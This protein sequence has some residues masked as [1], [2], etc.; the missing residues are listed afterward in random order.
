MMASDSFWKKLIVT[1]DNFFNSNTIV[2]FLQEESNQSRIFDNNETSLLLDKQFDA[3][4]SLIA[5]LKKN[6]Y[7]LD[8]NE[9]VFF[10]K[11]RSKQEIRDLKLKIQT[12]QRYG[13]NLAVQRD[14]IKLTSLELKE[15]IYDFFKYLAKNWTVLH[16]KDIK[17]Y[18]EENHKSLKNNVKIKVWKSLYEKLTL[19]SGAIPKKIEKNFLIL[20]QDYYFFDN[21]LS[22]LTL[23]SSSLNYHSL[24]SRLKIDNLIAYI[25]QESFAQESNLFLRYFKLDMGSVILFIFVILFFLFLNYLLYRRLYVYFKSKILKEKDENDDILLENL[26]KIRRPVSLFINGIGL[27]LALEVLDYPHNLSEKTNLYFAL[28]FIFLLSYIAMQIIENLFFIYFNHKKKK[29]LTLRSELINLM[30]S[31]SKALILL[32]AL[33]VILLK[34]DINVSGVI[35]SLGIGGLAVALAAKDTLSN[36]F[37]LLKIIFDESFSQGDWI[38]TKDVEGTVVEIGFIST[39]IRTF[40]NAMITV[41]NEKLANGSIKNWSRRKVGRRIK[42]YIG[43]TYSSNLLDIQNAINEIQEMLLHHK[44]ISTS[45]G[46]NTQELQRYY[47]RKNKLVSLDNKIG[48]KSTLLV[49]LDKFSNSSIDILIYCFAKTTNWEEWLAVKQDVLY[50]V[51]EILNK[52]NLEFAFPSQSIYLEKS[53]SDTEII[54]NKKD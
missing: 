22:Y 20:A 4:F 21:F 45:A 31:V 52:N 43:V 7:S 33:I 34:M 16:E 6:P 50:K 15:Q 53:K 1:E 51:W 26:R 25:N 14:T 27:K 5:L 10:D 42:L 54:H 40:D 28:F 8:Q 12:N 24:S 37:G 9:T 3:F 47:R 23:N 35:A 11:K 17:R 2:S 38:V 39:K 41:P 29:N 49:Y 18:I 44:G 36:F 46:I 19:Q 48:I 32:V 13:Y 30:L